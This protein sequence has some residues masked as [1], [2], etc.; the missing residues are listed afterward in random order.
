MTLILEAAVGIGLWA[1]LFKDRLYSLRKNAVE[2]DLRN[3]IGLSR[4]VCGRDQARALAPEVICSLWK[5]KPY[6]GG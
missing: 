5:Q 1:F 4:A 6:L 3:G 2:I